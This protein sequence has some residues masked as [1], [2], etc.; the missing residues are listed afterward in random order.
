MTG[1]RTVFVV[2]AIVLFIIAAYFG[3]QVPF[4]QI[5]GSTT[6][7]GN[8]QM[9]SQVAIA[10][11]YVAGLA[12]LGFALAGGLTLIAAAILKNGPER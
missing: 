11:N 6:S 4:Q 5:S 12:S 10:S 9:A 2:I 3:N 8:G 7:V 1:T